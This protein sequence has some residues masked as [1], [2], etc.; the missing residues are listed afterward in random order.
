MAKLK[1]QAAP[2]LKFPTEHNAKQ[3][4]AGEP[5]EVDSSAY[6]RRA[7]T[8]GDLVLVGD[9]PEAPATL[10]DAGNESE[11]E[12]A[13]TSAPVKGKTNKKASENE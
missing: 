13:K 11:A 8:D 5:V 10:T 4:I 7:L 1:V 12:S 3:Y 2:G 9:K 6:Y